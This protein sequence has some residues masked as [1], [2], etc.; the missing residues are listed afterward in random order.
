MFQCYSMFSINI[1]LTEAGKANVDKV[2]EAIFSYLKMLRT[3]HPSQRIFDELQQI[4]SLGFE[5]GAEP[6]PSDNVEN[7][8]ESMQLYPPEM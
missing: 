5:F 1:S 6:Q 2:L 8:A 7:L 3:S 4:K